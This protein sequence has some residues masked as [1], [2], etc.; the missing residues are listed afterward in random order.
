M[1]NQANQKKSVDLAQILSV[2]EKENAFT[3]ALG[4]HTVSFEPGHSVV[5]MQI[6][7]RHKNL[8]RSVHGGCIYS[9]ADNAS[10]AAASTDGDRV[11]TMSGDMNFVRPAI[12]CE[13]LIAEGRTLKSGKRVIVV[14]VRITD[15]TGKLIAVGLFNMSRMK[16]SYEETIPDA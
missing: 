13:K 16:W 8:N 6:D 14:E 5:E 2:R 12:D 9:L 15:E 11:V 7:A 1:E 4:I 3:N 10:G